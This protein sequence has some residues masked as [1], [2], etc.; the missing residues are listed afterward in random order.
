MILHKRRKI[1]VESFFIEFY[2]KL[3]LQI[4]KSSEKE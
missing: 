2:W 3:K 4:V 1:Y